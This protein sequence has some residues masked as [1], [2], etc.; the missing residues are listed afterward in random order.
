[1]PYEMATCLLKKRASTVLVHFGHT[2]YQ[3]H[4]LFKFLSCFYIAMDLRSFCYAPYPLTNLLK[5]SLV[6]V[7]VPSAY[8]RRASQ[9]QG[10]LPSFSIQLIDIKHHTAGDVFPDVLVVRVATPP[11]H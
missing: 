5:S 3:R 8:R 4:N 10:Q 11:V 9:Q 6:G 1:M 7:A 2:P